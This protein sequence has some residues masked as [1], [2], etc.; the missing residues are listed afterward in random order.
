MGY[1]RNHYDPALISIL[2]YVPRLYVSCGANVSPD[3][4]IVGWCSKNSNNVGTRTVS[5]ALYNV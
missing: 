2:P 5:A 4:I 3:A 1:L